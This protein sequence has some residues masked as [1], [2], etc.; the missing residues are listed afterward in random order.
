MGRAL[1]GFQG[2]HFHGPYF[3][4]GDYGDADWYY[5]SYG[6]KLVQVCDL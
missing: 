6:Y 5:A 4:L 2:H 3:G 1:H